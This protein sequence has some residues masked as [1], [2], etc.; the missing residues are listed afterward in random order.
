MILGESKGEGDGER[1]RIMAVIEE[2]QKK[3]G[4]KRLVCRNQSRH[5]YLPDRQINKSI[6]IS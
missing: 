4:D 3:D 6:S 2:T 5:A 1:C